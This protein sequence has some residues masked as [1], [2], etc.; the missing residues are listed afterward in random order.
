MFA[1]GRVNRLV[2]GSLALAGA[3]IL[4]CRDE[5]ATAPHTVPTPSGTMRDLGTVI[6][7]VDLKN[8]TVTTHP[9]SSTEKLPPGV[10]ARFYGTT[11]QIEYILTE[12]SFTDLGST[13]IQYNIHPGI[14]NLLT[15]AIGTN[16][17]HTYPS[18]PQDTMGVYVYYAILPYNIQN[19]GGPCGPPTCTVRVDSADGVFPF[20]NPTPQPYVY[21]KT[22]LEGG[23]TNAQGPGPFETKQDSVGGIDYRRRMSFFTHGNVTD[24]SFGL[25]VAAPWVEP[26]ENRWK[27]FYTA[28]SLPNRVDLLHLRSEPDWR[29]LGTGGGAATIQAPGCVAGSNTCALQIVS[30]TASAAPETLLYYRSDSL[31]ASQDGYIAATLTAT[32]SAL[33]TT[34]SVF[35]G[36]KDPAKLV[37]LGI[38]STLTGFTDA[39]GAF[40]PGFTVPTDP[41]RTSWRVSKVGTTSASIYS[42]EIGAPLVTIPYASLPAAPAR[43]GNPGDYDQFFFFGNVTQP[44]T[45]PDATSLW[46]NVNYE[47][48]VLGP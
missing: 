42:P 1:F 2:L 10:S 41:L 18:F 26:H 13:N 25:A 34:P 19:L 17:P 40:I 30:T 46:S 38:S 32:P 35:L 16:S 24:F 4:G 45:S 5:Q 36:L 6:V 21:W 28:D 43:G 3:G 14:S 27:V 37:R 11:T 29:V 33:S 15:F 7:H 22:I 39:S 20:T 48:G 44:V 8:H 47:I 23:G 12:Q 9:L 31:R